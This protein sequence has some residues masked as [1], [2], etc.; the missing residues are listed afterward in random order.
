MTMNDIKKQR[1]RR[2]LRETVTEIDE[3]KVRL[4]EIR[5][6][7][8]ELSKAMRTLREESQKARENAERRARLKRVI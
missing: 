5:A 4:A 8:E 6:C 3:M 2:Q 7:C 1:L